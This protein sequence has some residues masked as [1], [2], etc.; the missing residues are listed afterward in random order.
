MYPLVPSTI[1]ICVPLSANETGPEDVLPVPKRTGFDGS[2]ISY[3]AFPDTAKERPLEALNPPRVGPVPRAC[4]FYQFRARAE[5][6]LFPVLPP[7]ASYLSRM[8]LREFWMLVFGLGSVYPGPMK[9]AASENTPLN[10]C[11]STQ[12]CRR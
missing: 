5:V 11:L 6:E 3:S 8:K 7:P 2:V 1:T 10:A 9:P 12:P 4:Q